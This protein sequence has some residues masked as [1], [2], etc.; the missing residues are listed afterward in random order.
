MRLL[1]RISNV[2][3]MLRARTLALLHAKTVQ[4]P[5][6]RVRKHK[7]GRPPVHLDV[8]EAARLRCMG[9]SNRKIARKF[10]VAPST[11]GLRLRDYK[12]PVVPLV[13]ASPQPKPAPKPG[14]ESVPIVPVAVVP[15]DPYDNIQD[16]R[17]HVVFRHLSIE[18]NPRAF[19]LVKGSENA[20]VAAN[21]GLR[22]IGIDC[23]H[24]EYMKLPIFQG[25]EKLLVVLGSEHLHTV[26]KHRILFDRERQYPDKVFEDALHFQKFP[27]PSHHDKLGA[28][29][30]CDEDRAVIWS[31]SGDIWIRERCLVSAVRKP[32]PEKPNVFGRECGEVEQWRWRWSGAS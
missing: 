12:A 4:Q 8:N 19:F 29:F 9:W 15:P 18:L 7:G 16:I 3:K 22:A 26:C 23:W 30:T 5:L 10:E 2:F 32:S 13:P 27:L 11:V 24:H 25:A 17:A 28:L 1:L 31:I 21:Y 20:R 6:E 14:L